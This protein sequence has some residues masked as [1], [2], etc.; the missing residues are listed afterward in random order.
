[1]IFILKAEFD[2]LYKCLKDLLAEKGGGSYV[3]PLTDIEILGVKGSERSY[4]CVRTLLEY[5]RFFTPQ[6]SYGLVKS[7]YELI[8]FFRTDARGRTVSSRRVE[9]FAR[10][11]GYEDF[12]DFKE[13]IYANLPVVQYK[14]LCYSERDKKTTSFTVIF[15]Q[16]LDSVE[17]TEFGYHVNAPELRLCG[18]LKV[19]KEHLSIHVE[20]EDKYFL[21]FHLK[22]EPF[23]GVSV[24]KIPSA[25]HLH[26]FLTADFSTEGSLECILTSQDKADTADQVDFRIRKIITGKKKV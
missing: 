13:E 8:L 14:G 9:P 6:E 19:V 26:G 23:T 4:L 16:K 22:A 25:K 12:A 21:D 3:L 18:T 15:H 17:V 7:F 1:M 20:G 11:L 5:A 2:Y 24:N 10:L